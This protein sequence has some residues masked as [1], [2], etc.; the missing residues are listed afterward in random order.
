MTGKR[1]KVL[2]VDDEPNITAA[3]TR[4][5]RS[6][7][8]DVL[9]ASDAEEALSLLEENEIDVVVTDEG[10]PGVQ[11]TELLAAARHRWPGVA[12]MM[13]TGQT[14]LEVA[15][16]AINEGQICRFFTKPCN[17][18]D[19]V[20]GIRSALESVSLRRESGRMLERF[21]RQRQRLEA[22]ELEHPEIFHVRRDASGAVL[23]DAQA[24]PTDIDQFLEEIRSE[25][26]QADRR[27][28]DAPERRTESRGR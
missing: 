23:V 15:K 27:S 21:R 28:G 7:P 9:A 1:R 19:L 16:R 8:Y 22:L 4:I 14:D 25:I 5:L 18:F 10:L 11:G 13:L 6:E 26:A 20:F 3:L 2:L 17:K 24:L 12:R